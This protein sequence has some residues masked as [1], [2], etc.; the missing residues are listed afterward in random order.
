MPQLLAIEF[1]KENKIVGRFINFILHLSLLH[2]LDLRARIDVDLTAVKLDLGLEV[3]NL[4]V[5]D[6]FVDVGPREAIAC[7]D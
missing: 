1:F 4:A 2:L 6:F 3:A 7:Q 5:L